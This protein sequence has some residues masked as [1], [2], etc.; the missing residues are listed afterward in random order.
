MLL[1]NVDHGKSTLAGRIL[2]NINDIDERELD[3][4]KEEAEKN[5]M[6]SWYLAYLMDTDQSEREKGKTVDYIYKEISYNNKP[7]VIVDVPGHRNYVPH[8]I[9]GCSMANIAVIILSARKGEY[10]AGLKGQSIEHVLIARGMGISTLIVAINKMDTVDWDLETYNRIKLDFTKRIKKLQFKTIEFI[11]ISGYDGDNIT[12]LNS[13]AS[14]FNIS[15]PLMDII[16]EIPYQEPN[17]VAVDVDES[18]IINTKFLY[19]H[20]PTLIS[21][22]LDCVLH[23]HDQH[24]EVTIVDIQNN[25]KPYVTGNNNPKRPVDTLIKFKENPGTINSNLVVR[26]GDQTIGLARIIKLSS[27]K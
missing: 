16:M 21:S 15:K 27:N 13:H 17:H 10:E 25:G 20:I 12:Q 23:S 26:L 3:K 14:K 1:G 5:N 7:V 19:Y 11:P 18:L 8:M 4:M 6:Q 2:V 24:Y 22:G 9:N